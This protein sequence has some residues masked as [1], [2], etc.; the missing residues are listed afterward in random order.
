MSES[1]MTES[2]M[3]KKTKKTVLLARHKKSM[4]F[5][6]WISKKMDFTNEE[7]DKF[8]G[9]LQIYSSVDEQIDFYKS[10]DNEIDEVKDELKSLNPIVKEKKIKSKRVILNEERE[11]KKIKVDDSDIEEEYSDEEVIYDGN[12]PTWD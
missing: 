6:Y 8:E 11:V 2:I 9:L 5:G 10:F 3:T 12:L 4:L 1:I 7:Q